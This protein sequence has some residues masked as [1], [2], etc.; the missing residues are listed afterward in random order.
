MKVSMTYARAHIFKRD[1]GICH[2]CGLD[3]KN[4]PAVREKAAELGRVIPK[5][6]RSFWDAHHLHARADAGTN[7]ENN[8]MTCCIFCHQDFTELQRE[9]ALEGRLEWDDTEI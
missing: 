9:E 7:D 8:L 3:T 5:H 1:N 2:I 4:K 6:R